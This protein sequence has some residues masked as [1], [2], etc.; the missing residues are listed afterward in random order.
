[1]TDF[2]VIPIRKL[3]PPAARTGRADRIV[4]RSNGWFVRIGI[5]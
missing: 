5:A 4:V 2:R 3:E 1:M